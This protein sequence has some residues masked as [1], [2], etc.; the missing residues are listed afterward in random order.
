MEELI[1]LVKG[2]TNPQKLFDEQFIH[3]PEIEDDTEVDDDVCFNIYYLN[4]NK[5]SLCFDMNAE[6]VV[7]AEAETELS[8]DEIIHCINALKNGTYE[9]MDN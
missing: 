7:L 4:E 6:E 2:I 3:I 8:E 1:E 9:L 5:D